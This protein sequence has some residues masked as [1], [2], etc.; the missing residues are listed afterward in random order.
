MS[1]AYA[2]GFI[3]YY[4]DANGTDMEVFAGEVKLGGMP[5]ELPLRGSLFHITHAFYHQDLMTFLKNFCS[6]H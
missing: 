2:H 4:G 6:C 3:G 5:L 1:Y